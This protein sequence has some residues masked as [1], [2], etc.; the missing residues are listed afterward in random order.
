MTN[1]T[2]R[3]EAMRALDMLDEQRERGIV[4]EVETAC[5]CAECTGTQPI[6]DFD[7]TPAFLKRQAE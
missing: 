1:F 3:F 2:G 7:N 4:E 6:V 5:A